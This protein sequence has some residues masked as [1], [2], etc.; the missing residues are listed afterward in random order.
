M[1]V[2]TVNPKQNKISKRFLTFDVVIDGEGM[3]S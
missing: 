2:R 1:L 3:W